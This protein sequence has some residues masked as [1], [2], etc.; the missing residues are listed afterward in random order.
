MNVEES[1]IEKNQMEYSELKLAIQEQFAWMTKHQLIETELPKNSLF[2]LYL[3]KLPE[4]ERPVATCNSCRSFMNRYGH[5]VVIEKNK[6]YTLWDV[7]A[8]KGSIYESAL[9]AMG[10]MIRGAKMTDTFLTEEAKLG[11][12]SN[13][14]TLE[15]GTVVRWEHFFLKMPKG[16][17]YTKTDDYTLP[18]YVS[19]LRGV[20]QVFERGLKELTLDSIDT[21]LDWIGRKALY[22]GA[23]Y[24]Q[25]VLN[26]RKHH[27]AYSQLETE[28][29]RKFYVWMN[30]RDGGKIRNSAIGTLLIDLSEEKMSVED[31]VNAYHTSVVAPANFG[32]SIALVSN[33]QIEQAKKQIEEAGYLPSLDRRHATLDDISLENSLYVYRERKGAANV[34]D[35]LA[36]ANP[37]TA[38]S[39]EKKAKPI[40]LEDFLRDVLPGST[41]L[42]LFLE[43]GHNFMSLL[44]PVDAEAKSLFYW[45]NGISWTYQNNLTDAIAEKVKK[46]G[47][48]TEGVLGVSLEWFNYDDLDLHCREPGGNHM[49][50]WYKQSAHGNGALDV[51]MNA[52]G[53]K[54][55]EPVENII[56]PEMRDLKNGKYKFSVKN[57]FKRE[58]SNE[59]FNIRLNVNG[60]VTVYNF[61]KPVRNGEEID[62]AEVTVKD[63]NITVK[64]FTEGAEGKARSELK[65][66]I[67]TNLFH[68]VTLMLKSPNFWNGDQGNEHLFVIL[69]DAKVDEP[70]RPFFNEYLRSDLKNI[71][72]VF[73]MLAG[74]MMVEPADNQ[75]TGVGISLSQQA[76]LLFKANNIVYSVNI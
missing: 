61:P 66:G 18:G 12:D 17:L 70:L 53:A 32:H 9:K 64:A 71:R 3:S 36:A 29:H 74:R 15:D 50:Y 43:G 57:Y 6:V 13:R 31:A 2:D 75:V 1:H 45:K 10:D 44:A 68:P 34:F 48:N 27:V 24:K 41:D 22:R 7:L 67:G 58:N 62:I 16:L 25:W 39:L 65:C 37:V 20:R 63:G 51:D 73:E 38:R 14:A 47:G 11:V 42:Q 19:H 5:L 72:K 46:A 28:E 4:A 56:F 40:S 26:F 49:Y 54:T 30:Y 59:G 35:A 55:R 21:V 76:R 8:A 52:G 33:K 60:E 23:E 69:K